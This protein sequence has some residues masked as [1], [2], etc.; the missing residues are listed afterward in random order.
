MFSEFFINRPKFAF[1]ISILMMLAGLICLSRMPI[2]EYP[3]V[4]PPTIMVNMNYAGA[5]PEE[6]AQVVAATVE[7]QLVGI[8]DLL[9]FSSNSSTDGTYSLTLIFAAGSD[10]DM[11]MIYTSNA[12]KQVEAK[13]PAEIKQTGYTVQKRSGDMLGFLAFTC[14]E[15]KMS[16]LELS[17]WLRMN[18]RDRLNQID[19]VSNIQILPPR[20]YA[21]RVWMNPVR[22][23]A[24]GITPNDIS[25]A[26]S[27]QNVQAA[28]GSVGTED[29]QSYAT[30]K[31]TATGRLKTVEEFSD[32]IIRRGESGHVTRLRDVATVELGA[33]SNGGYSRYNG[34]NSVGMMISR[35]NS[36]NALSTIAAVREVM[37]EIEPNFP[38]GVEWRVAYDPTE[39]ISATITEIL[40]TLILSLSLVVMVTYFFLQ[41]WRATLIPAL[42]IPVSLLGAGMMMYVLGYSINVLTMFGMVLVIGSL[43]DDA[44]VVVEN[45][46]RIMHEERLSAREATIKSMRQI[47]GAVIATTLVTLAVYVP[48]AFYGG[49]VGIIYIQFSVTM[50]VALCFSTFNALTLSPA[51]CALLLRNPDDEKGRH[52]ISEA[53]FFPFNW[54]LSTFRRIYLW[55]CRVLIGNAWLTVLILLGLFAGNYFYY[56]GA[57]EGMS[58]LLRGEPQA[59]AGPMAAKEK[60]PF[61]LTLLAP[62]GLKDSLVPTEDKGAIFVLIT[63]EGSAT[64]KQRTDKVLREIEAR[65][66]KIPGV[67]A[68]SSITGFSF[69]SGTG[70]GNGMMIVGLDHWDKRPTPDL[71]A[72]AI[73]QKINMACSDIPEASIM[74]VTPPAIMGLGLTGGVSAV[75]QVTGDATPQDLGNKVKELSGRLMA[76]PKVGFVRSEYN[77][78]T[79]QI[80]LEINREKAQSLH[81]P[82]Q[83]IF[84]TLQSVLASS[85][86]NDFT[87]NGFNF[88]VKIQ[89]S[90]LYRRTADELMNLMVRNEQGEM[91][92]MSALLTISYRM[93]PSVYS[94]FNQY[95]SADLT[96]N[97]TPGVSTGEVMTLIEQ[98]IAQ[99]NDEERAQKS[100]KQWMVSW[101]D[102]SYQERQN[103][104]KLG[105]LLMM[106]I[107]FAYLF[108]V[109]QY[110]SW[111]TPI[112]VM[113]SVC[114]AT[115]GALMGAQL[116]GLSLSIY[117]QLGILMLI[118]LAAKN[119]IL[120]VEFSKEEHEKRHTPIQ[121]AALHGASQRFRAVLMT[122]ISFLCGVFPMV[123]ASGSGAASRQEI[124]I[125]TFC[126]MLLSVIFG[127]FMVPALYS[128]FARMRDWTAKK[129]GKETP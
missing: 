58:R 109:A 9:Y 111:T 19:G 91:V 117:V 18:V 41:D 95:M 128:I 23:S 85:Y 62:E 77:A 15:N 12:I 86:I 57:P 125:T 84:S 92:P 105:S 53:I 52:P 29:E 55:G 49:M 101:K 20:D 90:A 50:C 40:T 94:R 126:G 44:I 75:L 17:N 56:A 73:A 10:D 63:M 46:M 47:T 120:I 37:A 96:I 122:A 25:N 68:T 82:V 127:I 31:V 115:M 6:L 112:P 119:A 60:D 34:M 51:L 102:L 76:D 1:V 71:H 93:G 59:P 66:Q 3:E 104:G 121:E 97:P 103:D 114:V 39:A 110:E 2:A 98:T 61:Y 106:A 45:V 89:G 123:V 87:L 74:A 13:L 7:E 27:T 80:F 8:E 88:K 108:L 70:E 26:I 42:T 35:N 99:I 67:H 30:F 28:A 100:G 38:E 129:L 22:M 36:A 4:S 64:A 118:G 65:V 54:V 69:M 11:A 116:F 124:G 43:V 24:L 5:S 83:N 72:A 107:V 32:I 14:D 79:A 21:M 33:E 78:D 16:V 48:I 81:V 113:F